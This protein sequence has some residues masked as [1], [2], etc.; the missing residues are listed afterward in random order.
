[1]ANFAKEFKQQEQFN[2]YLRTTLQCDHLINEKRKAIVNN[3]TI[4]QRL[5]SCRVCNVHGNAI[6][7][8]AK[9]N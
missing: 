9:K 1:M 2:W 4:I 3:E 5:I 7:I 6:D 8:N